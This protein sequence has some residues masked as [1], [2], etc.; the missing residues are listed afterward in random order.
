[1]TRMVP[2][3][4]PV[5]IS[6]LPAFVIGLFAISPQQGNDVEGAALL[7]AL[8][9]CLGFI[10]AAPSAAI[11]LSVIMRSH[12]LRLSTF[13]AAVLGATSPII[14]FQGIGFGASPVS[15]LFYPSSIWEVNA[16]LAWL[17]AVSYYFLEAR[18]LYL[19]AKRGILPTIL[20]ASAFVAVTAIAVLFLYTHQGHRI[21]L[22]ARIR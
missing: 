16:V 17:I 1:M 18:I 20:A 10:V 13:T 5:V 7:V 4:I 3:L 11:A 15:L 6:A 9:S 22:P 8:A 21:V 19:C 2:L 12:P 14:I